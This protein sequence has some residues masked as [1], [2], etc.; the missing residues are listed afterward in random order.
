MNKKVHVI[1]IFILLLAAAVFIFKDR[2]EKV[3][4]IGYISSISGKFSALGTSARNGA[5]LA[6]EE[7]NQQ[8]GIDGREIEMHVKDDKGVPDNTLL[9]CDEF[10]Q[11]SIKLMIGP[12]TTA[13]ATA[14]LPCINTKK[15]LAIG[16]VTAGENLAG[17]DDMFIKLFPS[18]S[19]FGAAIAALALEKGIQTMAI[20]NDQQNKPFGD[21]L[22][23]GFMPVYEKGKGKIIVNEDY[24][25]GQNIKFSELASKAVEN[26]PKGALIIASAIDTALISQHLKK[27]EPDI[28]LF[29]SPWSMSK[30][31]ISSGGKSVEGLMAYIPFDQKSTV[32]KFTEF[33][34]KYQDRFK[35]P[36]PFVAAFNYEAVMLFSRTI[37][38]SQDVSPEKVKQK[39]LQIKRFKG[40]QADY[41]INETGDA[42]RH[43]FLYQIRNKEITKIE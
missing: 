3:V 5:L 29:V 41:T 43:L 19:E 42:K 16:P 35:E 31:L 20:I 10:F 1:V 25:S 28:Q 36:P 18:T 39:M 4:H 24:I 22:I 12:F 40:L 27:K 14:L 38:K 11:N 33:Q 21:T 15:I 7:L 26:R 8:G 32:E 13:S 37:E 6:V 34:I 30:E 9:I 2:G 17:K 23:S